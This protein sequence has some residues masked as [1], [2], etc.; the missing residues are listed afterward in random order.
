MDPTAADW[1]PRDRATLHDQRAA[2]DEMR[3]RCPVAFSDLLGWSLF[4]HQDVVGVVSDPSTYSSASKHL[5]IPA[6][7]DP[8]EHQRFRDALAPLLD[9]SVLE[10]LEGRC[11]AIATELI[12]RLVPS[13]EFEFQEAFA[14]P[15]ALRTLCALLGWSEE[16]WECLG[17]WAHGNIEATFTGDR[18]ASRALAR[19]LSDHVRTNLD[20][21]RAA[22]AHDDVTDALL[23]TVVD[24][25]PLD[26]EQIVSVLR[27]WIAGEG[28]V[29]SGL[30]LLVLQLAE[31]H[32]LQNR[33]RADPALIPAF[34]EEALRVDDP[35]VTNRRVTTRDVVIGGRAIPAGATL[36]LMWIAANRDPRAF[37]YAES[38]DLERKSDMSLV[39]GAGI[40]RCLGAP[41]ARLESR[42]ALEE[43]L[44]RTRGFGLGTDGTVRSAYPSNGPAT[45]MLRFR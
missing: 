6:G 15:F 9:E 11:R 16:M 2:Y 4:R 24:R 35:L 19:L 45:L 32:D 39:W 18:A 23:A 21:H 30:G 36:S 43:V 41:L 5:A 28:T 3:E 25:R 37:E 17:G 44:A 26:D 27:N 33:L 22:H 14:W 29:A 42:I 8:P 38:L 20:L 34:V 31:N 7:Q 1:D 40:H 10:R 13:D 12:T